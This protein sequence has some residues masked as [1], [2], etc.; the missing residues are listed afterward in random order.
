MENVRRDLDQL[1]REHH[2][3]L[4]A[5]RGEARGNRERRGRPTA[6]I[7]PLVLEVSGVSHPGRRRLNQD[8]YLIAD[9]A[10]ARW[11]DRGEP[12]RGGAEESLLVVADGM[13]GHPCGEVASLLA[14]RVLMRELL[15]DSGS[16]IADPLRRLERA[17]RACDDALHCAGSRRPDL[18][19]MGTTLTAA[20]WTPPL[21]HFAHVGDSRLYLLRERAFT[22]LTE[23]HTLSAELAA[24]GLE[25]TKAAGFEH[26]LT[27]AVG[28]AERGI[29]PGSGSRLLQPGDVL[30]LCTDGL[31][32]GVSDRE[33]VRS[34]VL[35]D[36]ARVAAVALLEGALATGDGDN[37]TAIVA[38]VRRA[39]E[40]GDTERGDSQRGE[41][42]RGRA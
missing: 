10:A 42:E 8:Q 13:G 38:R 25:S 21:L 26:V 2:A 4:A 5:S 41:A 31:V 18:A 16:A 9:L 32:R 40:R 33:I 15:H 11:R 20:W 37:V 24:T 34:L 28:G 14:V 19:S 12:A 6:G 7:A 27:Q 36:S 1:H 35:A 23:D 39:T 17:F 22:R 30:L 3:D 29:A